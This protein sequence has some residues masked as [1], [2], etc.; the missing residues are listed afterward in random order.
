MNPS[1]FLCFPKPTNT[2][3]PEVHRAGVGRGSHLMPPTLR[4]EED[5]TLFH[6]KDHDATFF[7]SRQGIGCWRL[8]MRLVGLEDLEETCVL[9]V[10]CRLLVVA[11]PYQLAVS[12]VVEK[13]RVRDTDLLGSPKHAQRVV[14][15]I[16][17]RIR[18]H[19]R[20]P[21]A[22]PQIRRHGLPH[23]SLVAH[24]SGRLEQRREAR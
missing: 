22:E 15:R 23:L 24:A 8:A 20:R 1:A 2:S 12:V 14:P 10:V 5:R 17:V 16:K 4:Y 9:R 3:R 13:V 19:G 21:R 11:L 6:S 7:S 18:L